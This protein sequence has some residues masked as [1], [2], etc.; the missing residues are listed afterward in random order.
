MLNKIVYICCAPNDVS[1]YELIVKKFYQYKLPR[2]IKSKYILESV[3]FR[4][5]KSSQLERGFRDDDILLVFCSTDAVKVEYQKLFNNLIRHFKQRTQMIIPVLVN[6]EPNSLTNECLPNT[7]KTKNGTSFD[8]KAPLALDIRKVK[9]IKNVVLKLQAS[10][11]GID[12]GILNQREKKRKQINNFKILILLTVIVWFV[13]KT[14]Y[15]LLYP[16]LPSNIS[17]QEIKS[18]LKEVRQKSVKENSSSSNIPLMLTMRIAMLESFSEKEIGLLDSEF[19]GINVEL[20]KLESGTKEKIKLISDAGDLFFKK[21]SWGNSESFYKLLIKNI[22]LLPN[23]N[24]SNLNLDYETRLKIVLSQV[25]Q[26][27]IKDSIKILEF[28]KS[29]LSDKEYEILIKKGYTSLNKTFNLNLFYFRDEKYLEWLNAFTLY[30]SSISSKQNNNLLIADKLYQKSLILDKY[31]KRNASEEFY[32]AGLNYWKNAFDN[33]NNDDKSQYELITER[34]SSYSDF[35]ENYK[36]LSKEINV[37]M[38]KYEE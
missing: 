24:E 15:S 36:N 9:N 31:M 17:D 28:L 13:L 23:H 8:E 26:G 33:L 25:A 6:G 22:K 10:I 21:F 3:I 16:N 19:K 20:R 29:N 2:S 32:K 7:L 12:Y 11:L 1:I 4:V 14:L 38:K 18:S 35:S 30:T 27:N 5:I 34:I 37:L